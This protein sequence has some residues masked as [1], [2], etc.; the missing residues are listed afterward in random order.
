[1][2][3]FEAS[4]S[5]LG[6][7]ASLYAEAAYGGAIDPADTVILARSGGKVVGAMRLCA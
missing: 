1:M 2:D 6:E 3:I 7:G 4:P 5:E